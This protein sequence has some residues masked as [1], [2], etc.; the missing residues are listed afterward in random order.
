M[1][2]RAHNKTVRGFLAAVRWAKQSSLW[3][4]RALGWSAIA[5]ALA[6]AFVVLGL[7]YWL[8]PN[9]DQYRE[10]IAGALS[11][12]ANVQITIGRISGN[13]DGMRPQLRLE[14][15]TVFDSAGRRSLELARVDSTLAW[16]TLTDLQLHFHALDIYRPRIEARRDAGG[17]LWVAGIEI[18]SRGGEEGGFA[19]WL[20][21]QRDVQVHD[22]TVS[23]SDALRKAPPLTLTGVTVQLLNRGTRHRFGL[24]A[25]PP[26]EL[27]GPLEVRGDLRGRS[28]ETFSALNGK[29]FVQLDHADLAAWRAWVELPLEVTRGR[30]ALRAWL[31]FGGDEITEMIAD[32]RLAEVR[33]LLRRE[34]PELE[35]RSLGGRLT[36]KALADGFEL[37]LVKLALEGGGAKLAPTDF[38]IRLT[39]EK[40][41]VQRGELQANA[42][43]LAA[44][45]M[46]ADRLPL[47][48]GLR[49][50]LVALAPRGNVHD[51]T[52]RWRG[53]WW[54]PLEFSARGRFEALAFEPS[55]DLP[56]VTGFSGRFDANEKSGTLHLKA[57]RAG[58]HLP[59]AFAHPLAL[60]ALAAQIAWTR[61]P[62][63]VEVKFNNVSF[64]NADLAG[65]VSAAYRRAGQGPGEIDLVAG[66]TRADARRVAY[67]LPHQV[68]A[69]P[70]RWLEQAFVAGEASD[71]RVKLQGPLSEFPFRSEH[72]GLF[73]VTARVAG[74]TLHYSDAWPRIH[75]IEGDLEFRGSR[76]Q[77]DARQGAIGTV[78]LGRVH[79]E[80]AD[81]AADS[82]L[83]HVSGEAEGET[84]HFLTFVSRSPVGERIE[85]FTDDFQARGPGRLVLKLAIPLAH[86]ADTTLAGN[87]Q[88]SGNHLTFDHSLPPLEQ[89]SGRI[90][91]T[92]SMARVPGLSG[93]FM[94]APLS[95]T[96]AMKQDA[97]LRIDLQGR[98]DVEKLRA[99]GGPD[100]MKHLQGVTDWGGTITLRKKVPHV[101]LE[102]SLVGISAH[103]PAPFGKSAASAI[104]LRIERRLTGA[105]EERLSLTYG[106]LVRAELVRREQGEDRVIERGV[107]QL[108]GAA[109]GE[110]D[111]AGLWLRGTLKHLDADEWLQF[112]QLSGEARAAPIAGAD[113][114]LGH[115]DVFGRRFRDITVRTAAREGAVQIDLAG[116]QL[117]GSAVWRGE[118]SGSLSAQ[119]KRLA[120]PEAETRVTAA[121]ARPP[122]KVRELPALDVVVDQFSVGERQL[123]AL[124]LKAVHRFR[125]WRIERL[126]LAAPESLLTA[127]GVW[128]AWRSHPRTELNVK[129]EVA[130]IGK[131]LA[132]WGY[133]P[134]VRGGNAKI[135]GRL[136]WS[137]SPQ[138]FDY[139]T[140]SGDFVLEA[141][142]GQFVKLEPGIAKLL[143]IL[144]LQALPRRITLDFRDVFSEGLAFDSIRAPVA[145]VRGVAS[146]EALRIES[147]SARVLMSGDVDLARE[148]QKLR[149][150]VSPHVAEGVSIAGA[151][152]GGPVAGI[153]A[154]LAQK[155][156]RDPLEQLISFEYQVTGAWSEP[157]VTRTERPAAAATGSVP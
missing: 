45:V 155:I 2:N 21:Q 137:G 53:E 146:T 154:Y 9:V 140:L 128:Q 97:T 103:F 35:L 115:L 33:T 65:T 32:V 119:L 59:R 100:W 46:L 107:V 114:R 8:L 133:P 84:A 95:L 151:L 157:Q 77:F 36:W 89:A 88:L 4:S 44:L 52:V 153:A 69:K 90:E 41:G 1:S 104:P 43:D 58:V 92:E 74:G 54:Q 121:P 96:A 127:D 72:R 123:G 145:V 130:D 17:V 87:L 47:D 108:G 139:P 37:A 85:R 138:E 29:L 61:T 16:R 68:P 42:F 105:G 76:M 5:A 3:T 48:A 152:L 71:V 106:E 7:R 110:P 6:C 14:E 131:A 101:V 125:D 26:P 51:A 86:A 94:G 50:S 15:V 40:P 98:A 112:V 135:E 129:M 30:G 56:G 113:L 116:S 67:Y 117:Q 73:Q 134:G 13:W 93:L 150:R 79:A 141:A 12:A 27:A 78:R 111:R 148:T 81:V 144:S 19:R 80:I 20:F 25:V 31:T 120:L 62:A 23:W 143:G 34:L 136:A 99:A 83:L 124:E 22:A 18:E 118:G 132:R 10:H 142:K 156:L 28:L 126:R 64:A 38:R 39:Q 70:K 75:E 57:Q 149:V 66:L 91:F 55:G 102:S 109:A 24:R 82:P 122:E 49:K 60:D 147:P 63:H 11:R